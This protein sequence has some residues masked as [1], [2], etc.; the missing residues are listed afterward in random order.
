MWSF[1]F[2]MPDPDPL[3][4]FAENYA[5][6]GWSIFPLRP[7]DKRPLTTHGLDDATTNLDTI[8]RWWTK[9]P[10]ANIGLNCG[11]SG[12]VVVDLD[13][14]AEHDGLA[15]WATLTGKHHLNPHTSTSLTGGGGQHLLFKVPPGVE[16]KNSAGKLAPGIDVRGEGG[17]IVL[18]PSIHPSG[19]PYAW[20]DDNTTIEILPEPVID[21]LTHEPDPWQI[22]T[23][24]DAFA[25]REPLVWIVDE[26]IS[27][28]SLNIFYGAPGTLKSLLLADMAVCVASGQRWLT[29]PD[30]SG[31]MTTAP[32]AVM[33]L[34]F[35]NGQRR[36][37][38]RFAAL[39]RSHKL[40]NATPIYYVSM[41]DPTLVTSDTD[42]IRAL[43]ARILDR[44]IGLVIID[45][46]GVIIG[47][48]DENSPDMHQPMAGLR[49]LAETGPAVIVVHH[50]RK[51]NGL[52]TRKGEGLRGHSSIEGKLDLSIEI[53]R[54]DNLVT[55]SPAKERGPKVKEFS[56]TFAY[57]NDSNHELVTA[58]FWP[59]DVQ[60]EEKQD[61]QNLR[62]TII[63][64]V[65][66]SPTGSLSANAIFE[67]IGGNRN[68]LLDVLR[69]M[70]LEKQLSKKPNPR[71]G[72]L[73]TLP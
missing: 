26:M 32:A 31:G 47:D 13:K 18:P 57:E 10:D 21:I 11:K 53:S 12:L 36:T 64:I 6:T 59:V 1:Y 3:C 45:N 48:A 33:W 24:A 14:R 17:Y 61:A 4:K 20:A 72:F 23:L 62:Q 9:T 46:L 58:R 25:P 43:A 63:E 5:R 42:S 66:N 68:R 2:S 30:G 22:F 34:D 28:G 8:R 40:N 16:I 49:W 71:G 27:A 69:Q 52:T 44:N 29:A 60:A 7:R 35:D 73:L 55:V 65:R 39:A 50:Q 51:S 19:K 70:N 56:A 15:E 41:P 38:E 54:E 67:V 37:H